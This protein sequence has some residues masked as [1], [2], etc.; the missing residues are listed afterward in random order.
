M[1][2]QIVDDVL[3]YSEANSEIGKE[4][5]ADLA[6]GKITLPLILV[7]TDLTPKEREFV[8]KAL[9]AIKAGDLRNLDEV[10]ALV[11]RHEG[12]KKAM[13]Y[14]V[15]YSNQAIQCLEKIQ[16]QSNELFVELVHFNLARNK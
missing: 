12:P 6:E 2:F 8:A 7:L 10:Y 11:N 3:D 14:A 15:Q 5:N 16:L 9:L 4:V 1:A 13:D